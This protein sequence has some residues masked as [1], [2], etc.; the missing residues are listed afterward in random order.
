MRDGKREDAM[1]ESIALVATVLFCCLNGCREKAPPPPPP[2]AV[3]VARPVEREVIEWDE[4]QGRLDAVDSVE[5]RARVSGLIVS[6][7]FVEGALVK[8][9]DLLV[10][11]DVRPF[12][13]DL[14]SA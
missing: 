11:I 13:A 4:Y 5:V 1:R 14:D 12:R 2:P 7:P 8:K 6:E 9:G 3:T 10:E